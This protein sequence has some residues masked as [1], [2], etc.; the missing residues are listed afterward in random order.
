M[1]VC[2]K[3]ER[4]LP[5]SEFYAHPRMADGRLGKCKDC[6]KADSTQRRLAKLGAVREYDRKRHRT[7]KRR[8]RSVEYRKRVANDPEKMEQTRSVRRAWDRRNAHKKYAHVLVKRAVQR[9]S[10]SRKPCERCG[11]TDNIEAHHEDYRFPLM[12]NWLC[13]TCHAK[14]HREIRDRRRMQ[15]L[16]TAV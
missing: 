3:C 10:L 4:E 8:A 14:R 1:K 11:A 15:L 2:F 12:V 7:A 13:V 16:L 5:I 9:G 6:A